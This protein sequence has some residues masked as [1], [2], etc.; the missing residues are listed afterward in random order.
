MTLT[1]DPVTLQNFSAM[2]CTHMMNIKCQISLNLAI[3][4]RDIASQVKYVLTDRRT[5][6]RHTS[7]HI[8][9]DLEFFNVGS[10]NAIKL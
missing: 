10:K 7:K 6:E 8:A 9:S 4:Y 2:P 3:A 1:F 5:P